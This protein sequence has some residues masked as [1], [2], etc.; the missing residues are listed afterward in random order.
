MITPTPKQVKAVLTILEPAQFARLVR[1]IMGLRAQ[2]QWQEPLGAYEQLQMYVYEWLVH[3]GMLEDDKI[4]WLIQALDSELRTFG[5]WLDREY[6]NIPCVPKP[7]PVCTLTITDGRYATWPQQTAFA[8]LHEEVYVHQLAQP[9]CT[10]IVGDLLA[11]FTVKQRWLK[12]LQGGTGEHQ[13]HGR[14]PD[15]GAGG[16]DQEPEDSAGDPDG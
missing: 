10:H 7:L 11:I 6:D 2:E 5:A 1:V 9:G 12:R 8:D 13:H 14:S 15:T 4:R 3:L 16:Q